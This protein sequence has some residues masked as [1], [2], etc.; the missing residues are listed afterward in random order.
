MQ[1]N[2]PFP[3]APDSG[4]IGLRRHRSEGMKL[5]EIIF[6]IGLRPSRREYPTGVESFRLRREGEIFIARWQ[7]PKERGKEFSQ[8]AVDALREF[9]KEGDAAIDVGAHT[10]DS[11]LP[12]AL[13][14]GAEGCVF[15]LEPNPFVFK[16]LREN[17]GLNRTKTRIVPLMFAATDSDGEFEFLYSDPGY[18]NG[19]LFPG[20]SRWKHGHFFPLRVEGK[21]LVD[22][23]K[24]EFSSE[25]RRLRY[26]KIDTEGAD[27]RVTRSL[28]ELLL[29]YRPYLKSEIHKHLPEAERAGYYRDLRGL[30]YRV[31]RCVSDERYLGEVLCERDLTR[32]GHFDI[33][34]VPE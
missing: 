11:T 24:R 12:I 29:T 16:V 20:A 22:Y 18:C 25:L 32:G 3:S 13:A 31:H 34:A 27:R 21:N 17:A 9:L 4:I 15:A 6:G 2:G 19:G 28:R 10:G 5:K 30:G 7:H 23:L 26:V 1:K 8:A 33:F 14:V